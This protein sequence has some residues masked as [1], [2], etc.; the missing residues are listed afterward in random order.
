MS[1]VLQ[2]NT[3][4]ITGETAWAYQS[5]RSCSHSVLAARVDN[6]S[7]L[8][9]TRYVMPFQA[10]I[11]TQIMP[12]PLPYSSSETV[13]YGDQGRHS[14]VVIYLCSSF[15]QLPFYCDLTVLHPVMAKRIG[16]F[17]KVRDLRGLTFRNHKIKYYQL[18]VCFVSALTILISYSTVGCMN[19]FLPNF[20]VQICR[21]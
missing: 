5:N 16:A 6:T 3:V 9:K 2:Y 19:T 20:Y 17:L 1:S 15:C 14:R 11:I 12:S 10:S 18:Q 4:I 13:H 21:Q 7:H 8:S